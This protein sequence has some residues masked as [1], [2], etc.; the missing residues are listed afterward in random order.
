MS[1]AAEK[2]SEFST[3]VKLGLYK[4]YSVTI[5]GMLC[6]TTI[7][8][9]AYTIF[10]FIDLCEGMRVALTIGHIFLY[11]VAWLMSMYMISMMFYVIAYMNLME[12][13]NTDSTFTIVT[14][15]FNR[16]R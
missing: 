6:T 9:N 12:R 10:Q 5:F 4:F 13:I 2:A 8:L 3:H 15:I 11:L 16:R 14:H 1:K 7:I